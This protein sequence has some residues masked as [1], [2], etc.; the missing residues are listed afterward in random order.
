MILRGLHLYLICKTCCDFSLCLF[1][2]QCGHRWAWSS[3]E[4]SC[5]AHAAERRARVLQLILSSH[6]FCTRLASKHVCRSGIQ[7]TPGRAGTFQDTL[8]KRKEKGCL[9]CPTLVPW[10]LTDSLIW[11][12][13]YCLP[14]GLTIACFLDYSFVLSWILMFYWCLT[15]PALTMLYLINLALESP[16]PLYVQRYNKYIYNLYRDKWAESMSV[17][18]GTTLT[19]CFV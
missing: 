8:Q 17:V 16:T 5:G 13:Y 11:F 14:P 9:P 19:V 3:A 4:L 15:L 2:V 12:F 7:H 10:P 6:L 18:N 1:P